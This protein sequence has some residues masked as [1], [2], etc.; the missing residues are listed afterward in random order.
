[1]TCRI[2]GYRELNTTDCCPTPME[3][4]NYISREEFETLMYKV[5]G[6]HGV[7]PYSVVRDFYSDWINGN[8][9]LAEEYLKHTS[10]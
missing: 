4:N 10:D 5:W 1:M 2:C 6:N 8:D 3:S 9:I 7:L